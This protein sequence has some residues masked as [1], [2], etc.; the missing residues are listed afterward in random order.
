MR[1]GRQGKDKGGRGRKAGERWEESRGWM[2][3]GEE[4]MGGG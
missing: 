3:V 1:G 4:R 2:R